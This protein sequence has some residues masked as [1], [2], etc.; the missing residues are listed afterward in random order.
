MYDEDRDLF[1]AMLAHANAHPEATMVDTLNEFASREDA[2][3]MAKIIYSDA[4]THWDAA[5]EYV[6]RPDTAEEREQVLQRALFERE[7]LRHHLILVR[8]RGP[9]DIVHL[10]SGNLSA[11]KRD[12]NHDQEL[13]SHYILVMASFNSL[14]KEAERIQLRM[15]MIDKEAHLYV[16]A[17]AKL[18]SN[19][20]YRA[21][22]AHKRALAARVPTSSRRRTTE[23][24][25]EDVVDDLVAGAGAAVEVI[26][27]EFVAVGDA[28][29]NL[30]VGLWSMVKFAFVLVPNPVQV[31]THPFDHD[32]LHSFVGGDPRAPGASEATVQLNFFSTMQ[33]TLMVNLIVNRCQIRPANSHSIGINDLLLEHVY[34]D[35]YAIHDGPYIDHSKDGFIP[36][37][38]ARSWLFFNWA[39]W[40]TTIEKILPLQ[41]M[42]HIRNY[43]GEYAAMYFAYLGFYAVWLIA[44]A[45]VGLV[46]SIYSFATSPV[47]GKYF[48]N[49]LTI[50][51]SFF[52]SV[53]SVL[54]LRFWKR[55]STALATAW[56]VRDIEPDES[57]RPEFYGTKL[58]KDPITG[59]M[60]AYMP[61]G[62][63]M[64]L[65]IMSYLSVLFAILLM[66]GFQFLIILS[67]AKFSTYSITMS[68]LVSSVLTL[69]N[70]V[71][72]TPAYLWFS[73][74]LTRQEN[75]RTQLAFDNHLL[76]KNFLFSALQNYSYLFYVGV[77]K[78]FSGSRLENLGVTNEVCYA[79]AT[80]SK[81][82]VS[83]LML[84]MAIVFVGLQFY[85]QFA[86]VVFP[87][88][89]EFFK[90]R[91]LQMKINASQPP[92]SRRQAAHR[93]APQYVLDDV[94]NMWSRR[95]EFTNKT[96]EFGYV[97]LFSLAFPLAPLFA[98]ASNFLEVRLAAYR[99][100]VVSKRPFAMRASDIGAWYGILDALSKLGIL[101]NASIVAFSSGY[102]QTTFL[103]NF[104]DS[105]AAK[106][107]I[108]LAFVLVFEHVVL[109]VTA[110]IE[111]LVPEEPSNIRNAIQ[112]E[113]YLKRVANGE[114]VE[115]DAEDADQFIDAN[116]NS[117]KLKFT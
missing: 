75:H 82:C 100:V 29:D 6:V 111:W 108:Q 44:P 42:T 7:L 31:N 25:P 36:A 79:D 84:S 78:V 74:F 40:G 67:H 50:P 92:K 59:R 91:S 83:E 64:R 16:Q 20:S 85:F 57:K 88:I 14:L 10:R 27:N 90:T 101:V 45:I 38:N 105:W 65:M 113:K 22:E 33:R 21:S 48:D 98:L 15:D 53:W 39:R 99:L 24:I 112:R 37:D 71:V 110:A 26:K 107:G 69:I 103:S 19:T 11:R 9:E 117:S 77:I 12:K 18:Q 70:I 32:F 13:G 4:S 94:L 86:A 3:I 63:T 102:F 1:D 87:W 30:T 46:V 115:V 114:I 96:I 41:P 104:S 68:T 35:Y 43:F 55:R 76:V 106:L 58:R 97:V 109:L 34:A 56:D 93:V 61:N 81:G 54:F 23:F 5:L 62:A 51:F 17:N 2:D 52:M 47:I 116:Q 28:V 73:L 89:E 95:D 66:V 72:L 8:E 80:S 60:E 49:E